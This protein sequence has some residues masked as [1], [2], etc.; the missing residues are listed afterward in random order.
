MAGDTARIRQT[1]IFQASPEEVF[2]ALMDEKKHARFTGSPAKISRE[3]GGAF[4]V[5]GGYA[6]GK[7]LELIA[8]K[9]I[10][11]EWRASDWKRGVSSIAA[12]SI[13]G[14]AGRAKLVFVQTGVP[15]DAV[16][17]I[18]E[19]WKEYYWEPMKKMFSEAGKKSMTKDS[20]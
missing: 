13:S 6:T 9:R 15:R 5:F 17:D 20:D 19:G 14:G 2:E 1:V 16:E 3:V 8:G 10:V 11:Q 18:S 4:S 12:F 7:N